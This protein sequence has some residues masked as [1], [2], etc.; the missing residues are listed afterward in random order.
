MPKF[1][2][3]A[4]AG[5]GEIVQGEME[6]PE[7]SAVITRLQTSGHLPLS[8]EQLDASHATSP[9]QR[10]NLFK[11]N[12]ITTKDIRILTSELATLLK[13]G[14]PLDHA[15]LTL[16]NLSQS[17][18]VKTM[19]HDIHTRVQGGS[20]LSAAMEAQNSVFNPLYLNM[21]RAGE[22]GG[23]LDILFARLAEYLDRSAELRSTIMSALIY[24]LILFF[25][26]ILSVFALLFFVVPQFVPLFEDAGQTLPLPTQIVFGTAEILQSYWWSLLG[27]LAFLVWFMDRQLR[28]PVK[29]LYWDTRMLKLPLF[30][31]LIVKMEVARFARTL[32]TL[33]M[34]GVP[35]LASA[36]I[37]RDVLMNQVISREMDTVSASLE[38]GRGLARPLAES[39]QFPQLA[40]ELIQVGEETGQLEEMLMK[41]ADIYDEESRTTVKRLLTLLEPVLIIGLGTLIALIII[42]ILVAILSLNE[43]VI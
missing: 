4:V 9:L 39:G 34:N 38:Q 11:K 26:A 42:S 2:Y 27:L 5:N 7:Q 12:K 1:K 36:R 6:A 10:I 28:D 40:V 41:V 37:V 20:S 43:L 15:L 3:K 29:R 17:L 23:A 30:G 22:A 31:E 21:V 14:L 33:L 16:E 18:P 8:A 35:M 13:A 32:G 25:I 24:P 19:V